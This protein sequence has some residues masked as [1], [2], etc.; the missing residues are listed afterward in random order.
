MLDYETVKE[1]QCLDDIILND[2]W[3]HFNEVANVE[4]SFDTFLKLRYGWFDYAIQPERYPVIT[5]NIILILKE[6]L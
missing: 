5:E 6:I 1:Q 2:E 3:K 4:I